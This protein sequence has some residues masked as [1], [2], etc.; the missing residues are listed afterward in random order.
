MTLF[1]PVLFLSTL[2]QSLLIKLVIDIHVLLLVVVSMHCCVYKYLLVCGF[3]PFLSGITQI[4][5]H[6]A[7]IANIIYKNNKNK[8]TWCMNLMTSSLHWNGLHTWICNRHCFSN[9]NLSS[10]TTLPYQPQ[11][12]QSL[13]RNIC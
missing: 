5:I 11:A 7:C 13:S 8:K 3:L 9:P 1:T 10:N 6:S 12:E 4:L 2:F